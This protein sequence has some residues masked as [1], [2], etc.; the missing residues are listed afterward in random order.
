MKATPAAPSVRLDRHPAGLA[1]GC[2]VAV[3]HLTKRSGERIGK[4]LAVLVPALVVSYAIFGVFLA[5]AAV[6]TRPGVVPAVFAGSHLLIQLLFTP[7]L[8]GGSI[9]VGIAVSARS[10]DVRVAQQLG[11]LASL[12]RPPWRSASPVPCSSLTGS[13]GGRWRRCSTASGSSRVRPDQTTRKEVHPCQQRS[14]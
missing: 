4:A 12:P 5:V 8:A 10:A 3:E 2:A 14:V 7:L 9:W 11:V 13:G 1:D 6:F